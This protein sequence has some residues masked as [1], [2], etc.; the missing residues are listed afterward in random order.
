M[1]HLKFYENDMPK[2]KQFSMKH[3]HP[4]DVSK[5]DIDEID[6]PSLVYN[7]PIHGTYP[8]YIQLDSTKLNSLAH[9]PIFDDSN[10]FLRYPLDVHTVDGERQFD[11]FTRFDEF[12]ASQTTRKKIFG[13]LGAHDTAIYQK[14]VI[15]NTI[16][17]G[18][19][20]AFLKCPFRMSKNGTYDYLDV[21]FTINNKTPIKFG[22][23]DIKSIVTLES[24]IKSTV[25]CSLWI[26]DDGNDI[27]Y[28]VKIS[29][30]QLDC[31][32]KAVDVKK[33]LIDDSKTKIF[34]YSQFVI[35]YRLFNDCVNVEEFNKM[36]KRAWNCYK[37]GPE[38]WKIFCRRNSI[39]YFE[40][41]IEEKTTNAD[42]ITEQ[43][44]SFDKKTMSSMA[45]DAWKDVKTKTDE[46]IIE[47][48]TANADKMIERFNQTLPSMP[49]DARKDD[50]TKTNESIVEEKMTK[51]NKPIVRGRS[52]SDYNK[53]VKQYRA[54]VKFDKD[55]D[56]DRHRDTSFHDDPDRHRD[57]SFHDDPDRHRDTSFHDDPDRHR[58]TSFH[59]DLD[60]HQ[61]SLF[62]E[63]KTDLFIKANNAWNAYKLGPE[64]WRDFRHLN[65]L[66]GFD[67]TDIDIWSK[68]SK[69]MSWSVFL[70]TKLECLM[71]KK[72]R[73]QWVNYCLENDITIL[74]EASLYD[75]T[76]MKEYYQKFCTFL[77]QCRNP[78]VEKKV[79]PKK[80]M[81]N[82]QN[83]KTQFHRFTEDF[84]VTTSSLDAWRAYNNGS[85]VWDD[86]RQRVGLTGLEITGINIWKKNQM[87][88]MDY[89]EKFHKED[90]LDYKNNTSSW[91]KYCIKMKITC[92]TMHRMYDMDILAKNYQEWRAFME[93]K[94]YLN[95]YETVPQPFNKIIL[96]Y[97]LFVYISL[98]FL[99][100]AWIVTNSTN[101]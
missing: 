1:D 35:Q 2:S 26:R 61:D 13:V 62:H 74:A 90:Y 60:R 7:D 59:D 70:S 100:V 89:V 33:T 71:Y 8:L 29:I 34:A 91:L 32:P 83:F 87:F 27:H 57:T 84:I 3:I 30:T 14:C 50:K 94:S 67:V 51:K 38:G 10:H 69:K 20:I 98:F 55:H 58:D 78:K 15:F 16:A 36:C 37:I 43:F 24:S 46:P 81:S 101:S 9:I 49:S 19:R 52:P 79:D 76:E 18:S 85:V 17:P 93:Y 12:M 96:N 53:F 22:L 48:K 63:D 41:V 54:F 40:P 21:D 66:N 42:K 88:F 45:S 23:K 31:I 64:S 92:L 25:H 86:Y 28:G 73:E 82:F 39:N 5:L 77:Q 97:F 75:L 11:F 99:A 80:S 6:E 44:N 47:E 56:P 4:V 95:K 68:K 72:Y 65:F